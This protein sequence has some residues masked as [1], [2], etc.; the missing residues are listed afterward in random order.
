MMY[1]PK[2]IIEGFNLTD[3]DVLYLQYISLILPLIILVLDWYI[4]KIA[5]RMVAK[6]LSMKRVSDFFKIWLVI[7]CIICYDRV[8]KQYLPLV[9]RETLNNNTPLFEAIL[10]LILLLIGTTFVSCLLGFLLW[11]IKTIELIAFQNVKRIPLLV[12]KGKVEQVPVSFFM[13]FSLSRLLQMVTI[14][15]YAVVVYYNYCM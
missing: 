3:A 9:I 14:T 15:F 12:S 1:L 6:N 8:F 10:P 13:S 11:T 7:S 5:G 2:A 4:S